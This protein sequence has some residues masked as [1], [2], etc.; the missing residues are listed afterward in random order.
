MSESSHTGGDPQRDF[1]WYLD[2]HLLQPAASGL[3][4][5]ALTRPLIESLIRTR[6]AA[7]D[8]VR[9]IGSRAVTGLVMGEG[10][11]TGVRVAEGDAGTE[12]SVPADLV[13]DAAGRGS[14][15]VGSGSRH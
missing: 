9:I 5:I 14:R 7:L 13:V 2:G 10:R 15:A 8:G 6:T 11:I 4:N 1:H 3:T 12:Q